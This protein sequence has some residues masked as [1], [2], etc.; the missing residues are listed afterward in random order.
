MTNK[1]S[2]AVVLR[3]THEGI[4]QITKFIAEMPNTSIANQQVSFEKL[5][6]VPKSS[7]GEDD[8]NENK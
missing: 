6:I 7:I 3:T 4:A 8:G 5:W 2:Y 1:V